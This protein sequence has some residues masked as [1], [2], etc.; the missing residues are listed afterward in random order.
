[1]KRLKKKSIS[2]IRRPEATYNHM[3]HLNLKY[4]PTVLWP[5]IIKAYRAP[6]LQFG[7]APSEVLPLSKKIFGFPLFA[8]LIKFILCREYLAI[9]CFKYRELIS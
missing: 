5:I 7:V 9:Y 3:F 6:P 2:T 4:W 8:W 1:M